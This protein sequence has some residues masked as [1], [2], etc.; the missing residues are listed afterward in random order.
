MFEPRKFQ[1]AA[2]Y[3]YRPIIQVWILNIEALF[4]APDTEQCM[5]GAI[6]PVRQFASSHE[7]DDTDS[8]SEQYFEP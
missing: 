6:G 3:F 8:L 7:Q 5:V 1:V 2:G 4:V